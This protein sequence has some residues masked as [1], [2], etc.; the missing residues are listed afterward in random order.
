M[1]TNPLSR[2][3]MLRGAGALLALPFMESLLPRAARGAATV[4]PPLR[5][6]IFTVTGGTVLESWRLQESCDLA[7]TKLP[8]ILRPLEFAKRELLLVSGLSHSGRSENLN[9]HEHCAFMHLTAADT[10]KKEGGK[11]IASI[12]VDQ[13]AAK[14]VGDQTFLPSMELGLAGHEN[15]YSFRDANT[16][17]P[18]EA[19]PRLVFDRMFRGRQPVVPNWS[20]R[21]AAQ[22]ATVRQTAVQ[23]SY[24]QSVIDLV[25]AEAKDLQRTLGRA[26]S[27]RRQRGEVVRPAT[28][29]RLESCARHDGV[30]EAARERLG[31]GERVTGGRQQHRVGTT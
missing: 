4:K 12:S 23:D 20:R 28:R 9:G 10:V 22:A 30:D 11:R 2:R 21:A 16:P 3:A 8:S 26:D 29:G 13:A 6:G 14:L 1:N 5:T 27:R 17:A 19:N 15:V 25:L 7:G 18:F 24:D 31:G